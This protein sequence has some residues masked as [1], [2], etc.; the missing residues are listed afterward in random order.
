MKIPPR[1]GIL[2]FRCSERAAG[3]KYIDKTGN[4]FLFRMK[5]M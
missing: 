3:K 5:N 4:G 1:G 2:Y